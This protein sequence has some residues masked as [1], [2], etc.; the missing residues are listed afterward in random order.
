MGGLARMGQREAGE[1]VNVVY[2][3]G[4]EMREEKNGGSPTGGYL[5]EEG[6]SAEWGSLC[7]LG[8]Q[9]PPRTSSE[10]PSPS[11]YF[12]QTGVQ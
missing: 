11:L 4:G 6:T 10:K 2:T 7:F 3:V 1:K 8:P 5:E 12:R 9:L